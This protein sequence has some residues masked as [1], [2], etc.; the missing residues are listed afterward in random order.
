MDQ[1]YN[2]KSSIDTNDLMKVQVPENCPLSSVV[3]ILQ[4]LIVHEVSFLDGASPLESTHHCV[5]MW[6]GCWEHASKRDDINTRIILSFAKSLDKSI[7]SVAKC[8]LAADI[9]EGK[10]LYML[11]RNVYMRAYIFTMRTT[12][13]FWPCYVT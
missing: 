3:K 8:V 7:A 13:S 11:I 1:C 4:S 2:V 12:N 10:H 5:F 9:Y 6:E